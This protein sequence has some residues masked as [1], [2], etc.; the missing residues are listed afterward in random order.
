MSD[1]AE[2]QDVVLVYGNDH[3]TLQVIRDFLEPLGFKV[4]PAPAPDPS[5]SQAD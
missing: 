1:P 3:A 5:S 4:D 2:S